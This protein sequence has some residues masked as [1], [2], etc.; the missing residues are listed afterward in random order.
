MK[1]ALQQHTAN[2]DEYHL[3]LQFEN[4]RHIDLMTATTTDITIFNCTKAELGQLILDLNTLLAQINVSPDLTQKIINPITY[5]M[6]V[7]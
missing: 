4:G 1:I 7:K 6:E 5:N 3:S 2:K